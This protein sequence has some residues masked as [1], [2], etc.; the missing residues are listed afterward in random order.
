MVLETLDAEVRAYIRDIERQ[1]AEAQSVIEELTGKH[2]AAAEENNLLKIRYLE[3]K[4]R[5]DLLLFKRFGRA[6][7]Q[8]LRDKKQW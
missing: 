4:E 3:L 6:A 1:K 2:K 8:L 5:Y 7:E